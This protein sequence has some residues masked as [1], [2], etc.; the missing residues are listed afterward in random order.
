MPTNTTINILKF[1]L[2]LH[3]KCKHRKYFSQKLLRPYIKCESAMIFFKLENFR[4]RFLKTHF[5]SLTYSNE[6][7]FI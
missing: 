2:K 4:R 7:N 3:K 5:N 1:I 6:M